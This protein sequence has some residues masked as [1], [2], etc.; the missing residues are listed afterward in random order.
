M[1]SA[2]VVLRLDGGCENFHP[3]LTDHT[4]HTRHTGHTEANPQVTALRDDFAG[5]LGENALPISPPHP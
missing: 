3:S 1:T 5:A 2:G 4:R